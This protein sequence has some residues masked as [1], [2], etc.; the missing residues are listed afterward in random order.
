VN[1]NAEMLASLERSKQSFDRVLA[2]L[3]P[4]PFDILLKYIQALHNSVLDA[5]SPESEHVVS[6]PWVALATETYLRLRNAI[7]DSYRQRFFAPYD[8]GRS[9]SGAARLYRALGTEDRRVAVLDAL[10]LVS[11]VT[12]T[13]ELLRANPGLLPLELALAEAARH[14]PVLVLPRAN[15]VC[16]WD[17]LPQRFSKLRADIASRLESHGLTPVDLIGLIEQLRLEAETARFR[18]GTGSP[19]VTHAHVIGLC[20]RLRGFLVSPT[21]VPWRLSRLVDY[22][23]GISLHGI[24][25]TL[26]SHEIRFES[27]EDGRLAPFLSTNPRQLRSL[28]IEHD[29]FRYLVLLPSTDCFF[30]NFPTAKDIARFD[31]DPAAFLMGTLDGLASS[32]L[33]RDVDSMLTMLRDEKTQLAVEDDVIAAST[34]AAA[35]M[36]SRAVAKWVGAPDEVTDLIEPFALIVLAKIVG[37]HIE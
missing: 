29:G 12:W 31:S 33:A 37:R 28:F 6:L 7:V 9:G 8:S 17:T 18:I 36:A 21:A 32:G 13:C 27:E 16:R 5:L 30:N 24:I 23:A 22:E 1:D 25:K 10:L 11:R 2:G 4:S 15:V 26:A 3:Q 34:T 14:A 19:A 35:A 20:E